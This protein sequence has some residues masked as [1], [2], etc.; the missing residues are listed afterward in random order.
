[1]SDTTI[2]KAGEIAP[3][4]VLIGGVSFASRLES[5]E[6]IT[7]TPTAIVAQLYGAT[8]ADGIATSS[9]AKNSATVTI[10]GASVAIG[11]GVM[12]T[13]TADSNAVAGSTYQVTVTATTASQTLIERVNITIV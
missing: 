10:D 9:V 6:T 13:V 2:P 3:G 1:M 11:K 5:S 12:F 7:G 8:D 4:E